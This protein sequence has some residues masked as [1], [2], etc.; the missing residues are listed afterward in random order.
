MASCLEYFNYILSG[1]PN[2]SRSI[3]TS[4][5]INATPEAVWSVIADFDAYPTW[6]PF[7]VSIEGTPVPGGRLKVLL[8]PPTG[9]KMSF[10][11]VVLT[12]APNRALVWRGKVLVSGL[13]DGEHR[14]E[15]EPTHAGTT[16]FV[17]AETF[18]GILV[19]LFWNSLKNETRNGFESMNTALKA[20]VEGLGN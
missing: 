9:R 12:W 7:I 2:M 10:S 3:E 5:E 18:T 6:N 20:R 14:F 1:N 8:Q 17:H 16:R 15:L 13:F 19:P 11:P 4:I